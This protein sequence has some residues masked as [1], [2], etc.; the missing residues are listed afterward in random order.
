MVSVRHTHW[1]TSKGTYLNTVGS[2]PRLKEAA[3]DSK[4]YTSDATDVTHPNVFDNR[5]V[6]TFAGVEK[7]VG[8]VEPGGAVT[9]AIENGGGGDNPI[10][11]DDHT[12]VKEQLTLVGETD[13]LERARD[14]C[15]D[16]GL[17]LFV[18][19]ARNVLY[20]L[21]PD[22][23]DVTA[24]MVKLRIPARCISVCDGY[25]IQAQ[26]ALQNKEGFTAYVTELAGQAARV[27]DRREM[28]RKLIFAGL[29]TNSQRR[30]PEEYP[31]AREIADAALSVAPVVDGY[32]MNVPPH[33]ET[34][35]RDYAKARRAMEMFYGIE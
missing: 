13:F 24:S 12:P 31:T 8:E 20:N 1:I 11:P 23:E 15:R 9:W 5:I 26:Q 25:D 29:T 21:A 27:R 4:F 18:A 22:T 30:K 10:N 3:R 33:R 2:S 32:W 28:Q 14:L 17:R 35:E 34:G 16:R 7:V 6:R 19:P